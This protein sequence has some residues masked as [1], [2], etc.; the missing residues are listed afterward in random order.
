MF[1]DGVKELTEDLENEIMEKSSELYANVFKK[2]YP[3]SITV[4]GNETSIVY[5]CTTC[6]TSLKKGNMPSMAAAN[7]L[8]LVVVD[9]NLNLTELENNLIAQRILFQK[10]FQLPKSRMAACKDKLINIPISEQDVLNTVQSLPRTPNEAGLLEVKLKRK[11]EYKNVHQQSYID[12]KKS[13]M[14]LSF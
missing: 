10:I 1:R 3:I 6:K 8:E 2:K 4:D 12:P 14:L 13:M 9:E 7:G 11:M 5:I